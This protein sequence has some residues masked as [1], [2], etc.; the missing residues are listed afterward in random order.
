MIKMDEKGVFCENK[1]RMRNSSDGIHKIVPIEP[2][3]NNQLDNMKDFILS[4]NGRRLIERELWVDDSIQYNIFEF[5]T[6][7]FFDLYCHIRN[8]FYEK[9]DEIG[10]D[11]SRQHYIHGWCNIFEKGDRINWHSH[12]EKHFPNMYHGVF[13]I[14]PAGNSYTEYR[15]HDTKEIYKKIQSKSG[16]GHFICDMITEHRSTINVSDNPRITIAFDIVDLRNYELHWD[17]PNGNQ[18]IPFV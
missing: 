2:V 16:F 3:L 6:V 14:D 15:Y 12:C 7:G 1:E 11:K 4:P 5:P 9:G 10:V 18:F 13:C 17:T 8:T